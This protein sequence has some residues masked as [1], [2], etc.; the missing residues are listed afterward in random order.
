MHYQHAV[1]GIG[2]QKL[3]RTS[4][5]CVAYVGSTSVTFGL[6]VSGLHTPWRL[7][8]VLARSETSDTYSVP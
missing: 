5:V 7:H 8:F 6:L 3:R 1:K 2:S 4:Q